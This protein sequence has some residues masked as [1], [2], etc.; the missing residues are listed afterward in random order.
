MTAAELRRVFLL[1]V[2]L[3]VSVRATRDLTVADRSTF[4][5]FY[6]AGNDVK[7]LHATAPSSNGRRN[8]AGIATRPLASTECVYW[9]VNTVYRPFLSSLRVGNWL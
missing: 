8:R 9:P 5:H 7:W 6:Q 3:A 4:L 2:V 1:G